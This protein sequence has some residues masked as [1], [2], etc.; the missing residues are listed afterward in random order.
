MSDDFND[1]DLERGQ[2]FREEPDAHGQAAL[3]LAESIL[4]MLI[5]TNTFTR[6]EALQ[7]V[8]TAAEV[9]VDVAA[10]IGESTGRMEQ[11][12][13]LIAS[14]AQSLETDLMSVT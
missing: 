5:E 8:R 12:L 14:I 1:N 3:I 13:A 4:H 6:S 10:E 7:T 11:S 2:A 9:K